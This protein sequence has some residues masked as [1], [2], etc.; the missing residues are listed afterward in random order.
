M[1]REILRG[2]YEHWHGLAPPPTL[3][4][5]TESLAPAVVR[6]RQERNRVATRYSVI[7]IERTVPPADLEAWIPIGTRTVTIL[8]VEDPVCPDIESTLDAMGKPEI[9][10]EDQ[11]LSAFYLV[12]DWVFPQRGIVFSIGKPLPSTK[13]QARRLLHARFF[14]SMSLQRYLTEVG[15]ANPALPNTNG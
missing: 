13:P 7:R 1:F 2:R 12:S 6:S 3:E 5:I 11:R 15:E 10:L 14:A 8:E 4:E 9:I